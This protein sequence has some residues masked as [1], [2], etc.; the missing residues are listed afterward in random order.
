[1]I[2]HVKCW[3][4]H[5]TVKKIHRKCLWSC[6]GAIL[7]GIVGIAA[8]M[9]ILLVAFEKVMSGQGMDIYRTVWLV[10]FNYI[11]VL[12]LFGAFILALMLGAVFWLQ[13]WRQI[14]SLEK[15][16]GSRETNS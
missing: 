8:A 2:S 16:D 3:A 12:V 5:M 15:K 1:M 11:G 6:V 4:L 14:R 10:E 13:E 9:H 7:F